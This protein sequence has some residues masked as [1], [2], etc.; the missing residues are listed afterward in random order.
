MPLTTDLTLPA[1]RKEGRYM[2]WIIAFCAVGLAYS[3]V[4]AANIYVAATT[5]DQVGQAFVYALKEG[6]ASSSRHKLVTS[7]TDA[8]FRL[9][10]VTLNP[11]STGREGIHTVYSVT[12]T[13][14]NLDP[15]M[16]GWDYFV[17]SWVGDC[18]S[19]KTQ[20]CAQAV[21]AGA[22]AQMSPI[23]EVVSDTIRQMQ[24]QH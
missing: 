13:M 9:R 19:D 5:P 11:E 20:N 8:A 23:V 4:D 15:K 14:R 10:I 1:P 12:L 3:P 7:E 18:G 17:S 22:D 16:S 6:V 2:K 24:K 21:L